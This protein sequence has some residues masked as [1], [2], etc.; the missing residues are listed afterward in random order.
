MIIG[1]CGV[2]LVSE[3][4]AVAAVF[5]NSVLEKSAP[6]HRSVMYPV[7]QFLIA[8]RGRKSE[9]GNQN[10]RRLQSES[11][12]R[13]FRLSD[14]QEEEES[15]RGGARFRPLGSRTLSALVHEQHRVVMNP[16]RVMGCSQ[17]RA[18]TSNDR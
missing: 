7:C 1:S 3:C 8:E 10:P 2:V 6:Y 4:G 17:E 18:H 5:P 11:K 14:C 16:R 13:N 9:N 12:I 15:T